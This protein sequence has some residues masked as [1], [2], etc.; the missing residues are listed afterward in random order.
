VPAKLFLATFRGPENAK[1]APP[2]DPG[3]SEQRG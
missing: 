2:P 3:G 1:I